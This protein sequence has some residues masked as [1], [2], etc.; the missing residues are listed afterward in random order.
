MHVGGL[1][2]ERGSY[3]KYKISVCEII[4]FFVPKK[5]K[6]K[7]KNTKKKTTQKNSPRTAHDPCRDAAPSA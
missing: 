2:W 5:E 1:G 7:K 6:K 3:D 4:I